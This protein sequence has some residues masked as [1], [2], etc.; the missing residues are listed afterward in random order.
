VACAGTLLA[1]SPSGA[2]A[3]VGGKPADPAAYPFLAV[4]GG[5]CGGALIAPDRVLTAAHCRDILIGERYVWVGPRRERRAVR[6]L[7]IHPVNVAT[8]N[9]SDANPAPAD[10]MILELD[11]PVTD[12][13]PLEIAQ[14]AP[15]PG[16][17]ALTIGRGTTNP[18][19]PGDGKLRSG[20]VR[21]MS[22]GACRPELDTAAFREWFT[23]VRDPRQLVRGSK[24]PFVSGCF[25]DSG[26]PL[27]V[28]QGVRWV[29]VGV[30]SWGPS[31]GTQRDPEIYADVVAGRDFA[32]SPSPVWAPAPA[33]R[34]V[35]SGAARVGRTVT[36]T[37][38]F[39][40]APRKVT[41]EFRVGGNIE[42]FTKKPEYK[43]RSADRGKK[44]SCLIVAEGRG[45]NDVS[46]SRP[47][48]IAR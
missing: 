36:C 7:A 1:A 2:S 28:R 42:S 24:G 8:G 23:C 30:D 32:L 45:G 22:D 13:V 9:R 11:R 10:F 4:V 26:S 19:K 43:I 44:I 38:S 14:T 29:T 25:G 6:R 34:P 35:V 15:A 46:E 47:V 31:C 20:V 33:A 16:S 40:D 48:R 5:G 12:V 18:D 41:Y 39:L 3:V 17:S 21:V 27:L 37:A